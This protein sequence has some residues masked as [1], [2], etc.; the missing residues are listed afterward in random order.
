MTIWVLLHC[1]DM[2]SPCFRWC[3]T[4]CPLSCRLEFLRLWTNFI[5]VPTKK[6]AENSW[7]IS[8]FT[9][10]D[11]VPM[12][13]IRVTRRSVLI[14]W[15]TDINLCFSVPHTEHQNVLHSQNSPDV[16][17]TATH[18]LN[19]SSNFLWSVQPMKRAIDQYHAPMITWFCGGTQCALLFGTQT[20]W[21]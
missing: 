5:E 1:D 12:S 14:S 20:T 8:I 7:C 9:E 3:W 18:S 4:K 21:P 15:W 19:Q 2:M 13:T 16:R 10:D 17:Y 6:P 11:W